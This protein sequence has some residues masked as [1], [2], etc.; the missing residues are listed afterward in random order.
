MGSKLEYRFLLTKIAVVNLDVM[1]EDGVG[2]ALDDSWWILLWHVVVGSFSST[3]FSIPSISNVQF[4]C[5]FG[6]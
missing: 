3:T 4:Q 5:G 1:I 6:F 2:V